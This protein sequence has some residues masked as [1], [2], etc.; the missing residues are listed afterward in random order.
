MKRRYRSEYMRMAGSVLVTFR[1]ARRRPPA[2][3]GGSRFS[4]M[5]S[6]EPLAG[7]RAGLGRVEAR[8]TGNAWVPHQTRMS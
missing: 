4:R 1:S 3:V 7:R 6:W 8:R 5:P 2:P